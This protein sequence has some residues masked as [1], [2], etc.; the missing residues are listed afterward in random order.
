MPRAFGEMGSSGVN[1]SGGVVRE[2]I[3]YRLQGDRGKRTFQEMADNDPVIGGM[4]LAIEHLA[5][6]CDWHI[7]AAED[8]STT[9]V[10]FV[11]SCL[12]DMRLHWDDALSGI[13]SMLVFG[14]SVHEIVYAP[15]DGE[16]LDQTDGLVGWRK[17]A[18]R[19][20]T[21]ISRWEYAR[22]DL[23]GVTQRPSEAVGVEVV[24]PIE[25]CL[26]FRTTLRIESPE[27]RSVLRNAFVPYFRRTRIEEIEVIG[28]EKDLAGIPLFWV[29]PEMMSADATAEEKRALEE[30][31]EIGQNIR[32]D[33][34]AC[35][36]LPAFY[37][38]NGNRTVNFELL[39]SPGSK[40]HNTSEIVTR[41][42]ALIALS[43][44]EDFLM[45]GHEKTGSWALSV[46]KISLF[47]ET[48]N[49][50]LDRVAREVTDKA[51]RQL[52]TLNNLKGLPPQ[53]VH[54]PVQLTD[55]SSLGTF[56][57]A[58]AAAGMPMFPDDGLAE[59]LRK[60][61]GLPPPP[62]DLTGDYTEMVMEA[63]RAGLQLAGGPPQEEGDDGGEAGG[64]GD[65]GG[66]GERPAASA[67]TRR[68]RITRLK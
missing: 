42:N 60:L 5:L 24:M 22:G 11:Q 55:L 67:S 33:E 2:D 13:L 65:V 3:L 54:S 50:W 14:F 52:L 44:L 49:A 1:V 21:S 27:G 68:A 36:I 47:V 29:S 30:Y 64:Q 62:E 8:G 19:P 23:V 63:K 6:K 25:K 31:R 48:I 7:G 26:H 61:A 39:S 56:I 28:I 46:S 16:A 41:Y 43:L 37:D 35:L 38:D 66:D 4:L 20:Q 32:Q 12:D 40:Q 51:I 15:R 9:H 57:G 45:L 59:H 18:P 58:L 10:D 53:M 34:A 17:F